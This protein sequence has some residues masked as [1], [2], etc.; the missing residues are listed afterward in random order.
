MN[1]HI[2]KIF[3]DKKYSFYIALLLTMVFA[4]SYTQ[5]SLYIS[6]QNT[7]FLHGL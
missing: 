5:R 3:I 1:I 7:Y 4:I 6:N 2:N